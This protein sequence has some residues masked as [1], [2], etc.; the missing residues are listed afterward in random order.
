MPEDRHVVDGFDVTVD[1]LRFTY[2]TGLTVTTTIVGEG[3]WRGGVLVS[4]NPTR[5]R[6]TEYCSRTWHSPKT[7]EKKKPIVDTP[8]EL[9]A[10]ASHLADVH[11]RVCVCVCVHVGG[12][13]GAREITVAWITVGL[14]LKRENQK[15]GCR[16][17][18]GADLCTPLQQR[19]L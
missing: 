15:E 14:R 12:G 16:R 10:R 17:Q 19:L 18:G 3:R 11:L 8:R 1:A 6:R 13:G 5:R 2:H 7:E 4:H 9:A